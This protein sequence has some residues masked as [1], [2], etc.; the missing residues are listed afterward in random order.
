MKQYNDI[1]F[2]HIYLFIFCFI[3]NVILIIGDS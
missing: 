3:Y 2:N 1:T